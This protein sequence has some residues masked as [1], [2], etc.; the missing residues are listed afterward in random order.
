[1]GT[2]V[3]GRAPTAGGATAPP[4]PPR[5]YLGACPAGRWPRRPRC[6]R[7]HRVVPAAGQSAA[8]S[9]RG[10]GRGVP[11]GLSA[12]TP[13]PDTRRGAQT[14]PRTAP[15]RAPHGAPQ[16]RRPRGGLWGS[17]VPIPVPAALTCAG[18]DQAFPRQPLT[19]A[20]GCRGGAGTDGGRAGWGAGTGGT[21]GREGQGWGGHDTDSTGQAGTP[22]D[23]VGQRG[24]GGDTAGCGD[25]DTGTRRELRRGGHGGHRGL[26]PRGG[27]MAQQGQRRGAQWGRATSAEGGTRGVGSTEWGPTEPTWG[28]GQQQYPRGRGGAQAAM[29][30]L[31]MVWGQ[32]MGGEKWGREGQ[33]G[34]SGMGVG[35]AGA[36]V[37]QP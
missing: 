30:G 24:Q 29:G 5:P 4:A 33:A 34:H 1:M 27:V 32:G 13:S 25:G 15:L 20:P 35:W 14:L 3:P 31:G 19:A 11:W 6:T 22:W 9:P 12:P 37:G 36:A 2:G 23:H 21:R 17:P 10:P 7:C 8:C 18:M 16:Q 26:H 28:G